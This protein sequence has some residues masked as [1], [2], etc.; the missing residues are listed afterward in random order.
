MQ[1]RLLPA[2]SLPSCT[3]SFLLSPRES[4]RVNRGRAAGSTRERVRYWRVGFLTLLYAMVQMATHTSMRTVHD[5]SVTFDSCKYQQ[6]QKHRWQGSY[7]T[8]PP[9]GIK[10]PSSRAKCDFYGC[11]S[12]HESQAKRLLKDTTDGLLKSTVG[13]IL[14]NFGLPV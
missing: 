1:P 2:Y 9:E 11:F 7:F 13:K 6:P 3:T 4:Q 10:D 14:Q 8:V 12:W 5:F